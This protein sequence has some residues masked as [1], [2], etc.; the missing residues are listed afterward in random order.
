MGT[1]TNNTNER[2]RIAS[3]VSVMNFVTL[4]DLTFESLHK[5]AHAVLD[6]SSDAAIA[7]F[8]KDLIEIKKIT[9]KYVK[10]EV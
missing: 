3:N 10:R 1:P 6:D 5:A 4:F 8:M 7:N 2:S 9:D